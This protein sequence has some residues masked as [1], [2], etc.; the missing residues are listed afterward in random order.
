[1]KQ[2]QKRWTRHVT[3]TKKIT[4]V[5]F[6]R[7]TVTDF[8]YQKYLLE[9]QPFLLFIL[10]VLEHAHHPAPWRADKAVGALLSRLGMSG[11]LTLIP[12]HAFVV[13]TFSNTMGF[14]TFCCS[15]N[16]LGVTLYVHF[17]Y[18]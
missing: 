5:H 11:V 2:R 16:S 3:P 14:Y 13:C 8:F 12:S 6:V 15:I 1:M 4:Y 18:C 10:S 7:Q 9:K 17:H